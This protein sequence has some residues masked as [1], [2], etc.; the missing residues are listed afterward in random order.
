MQTQLQET[1]MAKSPPIEREIVLADTRYTHGVTHDGRRVWVATDDGQL[2]GVDP[3]S[4]A[5]VIRRRDFGCDAGLAFDGEALWAICGKEIRRFDPETGEVLSTVPA[6]EQGEVS[7]MAYAEG[8]LW[9]GQYRGKAVLKV[10][11]KTGKVLKKIACD[12]L[13]TGVSF[14]DHELWHGSVS[15]D[16]ERP[17][18][19]LH[20][21]DP[22]SLVEYERY[23]L[24]EAMWVSGLEIDPS[25][26]AF[27]AGGHHG[28]TVRVIERPKT[29]ARG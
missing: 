24:P 25:K 27:W 21:L 4:G 19:M 2:I 14:V 17:A 29:K 3:S 13:V 5:E 7:G 1:T 8:F 22:E 15:G 26:R 18:G 28:G 23:P 9:I 10:D 20:R 6:P 11:P 12:R 16:A